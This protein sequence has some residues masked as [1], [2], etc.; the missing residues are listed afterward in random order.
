MEG[1][2]GRGQEEILSDREVWRVQD[3]SKRNNGS[4]GRLARKNEVKQEKVLEI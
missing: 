4:K 3:R 2:R 1:F